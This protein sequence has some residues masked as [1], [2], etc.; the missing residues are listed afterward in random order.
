VIDFCN[1]AGE[2]GYER[3]WIDTCCIDKSS[4][5]ELSEAMN[6][7]YQWYRKAHLCFIYLPDVTDRESVKKS[8]WF[9]RGLTLQELLAPKTVEFYDKNWTELGNKVMMRD[10][11]SEII[12]IGKGVLA[13]SFRPD[14]YTVAVRM[15]WAS[16]R[17]KRV[18]DTAYSLLGILGAN[19]PLLYGEGI[20]AFQRLQEEILKA[21]EDYTLFTWAESQMIH[22]AKRQRAR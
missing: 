17:T 11:I 1:V 12:G 18:E 13:G 9:S 4:S 20:R 15:F 14:Q 16:M 6:L 8:R 3:I 5:A 19:M 10:V 21:T 2:K 22:W 7:M